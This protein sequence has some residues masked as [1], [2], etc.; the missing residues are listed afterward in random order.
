MNERTFLYSPWRMEYIMGER[1]EDCVFCRAKDHEKDVENLILHRAKHSY[2]IINRYPYN[3][4]HLLIVP[5]EHR[6]C[7]NDFEPEVLGEITEY[8]RI[9]ER[10]FKTVYH[11]DGINIG[12]NLGSA[13]GAGIQAHLHVHMVPRWYGDSNFMSVVAGERVIPEAFET[14]YKKLK[15]ELLRQIPDHE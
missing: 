6:M 2:I 12:I 9:I 13:A 15:D 4:G 3:N 7:L 10:V 1:A 8:M 5:Y 11:C 14:T